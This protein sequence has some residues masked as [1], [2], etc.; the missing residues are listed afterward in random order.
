MKTNKK[1]KIDINIDKNNTNQKESQ[2]IDASVTIEPKKFK[3][4]SRC[5][6]MKPAHNRFFSKNSTSKDGWYSICK[7]CRN[8]KKS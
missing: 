3:K 8:K 2:D 6:Q 7:C 5:G 1:K 4:C